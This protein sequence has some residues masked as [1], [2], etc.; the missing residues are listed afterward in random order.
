[1]SAVVGSWATSTGWVR[2]SLEGLSGPSAG[3]EGSGNSS[4]TTCECGCGQLGSVDR[5]GLGAAWRA[6]WGRVQVWRG[7]GILHL[8]LVSAVVGSWGA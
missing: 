4:F 6:S 2:G 8:P 3:L 5:G 7:V 1:M